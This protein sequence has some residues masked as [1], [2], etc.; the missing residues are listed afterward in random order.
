MRM[1]EPVVAATDRLPEITLRVIGLSIALTVILAMSNAYLALKIGILASASIPAAIISM[2]ILRRTKEVSIL[3]NNLVQ[4][5]ASAGEAIAGGIVYTA[6]ALILIH[7]WDHFSYMENVLIALLGGLLGIFFSTPLRRIFMN[8]QR[9]TFPEGRAIAEVLIAGRAK[10]ISFS[11]IFQGGLLGATVELL[12]TGLH[13]VSQQAQYWVSAANTLWGLGFGFS[14][15]MLGVGYLV[16]FQVGFSLFIGAFLGWFIGI[17]II[18]WLTPDLDVL[19]PSQTAYI[20]WSGK[21]RYVGVGAM[22][23]AGFITL[24]GLLSPFMASLKDAWLLFSSPIKSI[25]LPRTE[26]DIPLPYIMLGVMVCTGVLVILLHRQLPIAQLGLSP[27]STWPILF[28]CLLYVL[29][30]SF[31]FCT[32]TGYFSGLVGV[33][34]SPG[35]AIIIAGLLLAAVLLRL[36]LESTG[37]SD[38]STSKLA[39]AAITIVLGAIITGA[40]AIAN[41]NIQNLKV[42]H[43]LGGTPWKQQVMLILGIF[44]AA[45]TI[46]LV[47][48]LLFQVYGIGDVLPHP[49][50]DP[51]N[52][53]A[54]PPAAMMAAVTQGVFDYNLPWHFIFSG[55][56]II[57]FFCMFNRYCLKETKQFSLI[58]IAMG[59]YL[60][61]GTSMPL[62]LGSLV[63]FLAK[64][65]L[66]HRKMTDPVASHQYRRAFLMACGL[67]SGAAVMNIVL[68][69]PVIL[70]ESPD[71]IAIMPIN[72]RLLAD[73]LGLIAE[74]TICYLLYRAAVK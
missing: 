29:M 32:I 5:A 60:P 62:C 72:W 47:M 20:L 37:L 39:G 50:M 28:S 35:S 51:A 70:T 4:T 26:L 67:V 45:V 66:S 16:G 13:V 2:A 61:L 34:A 52:A 21:L 24:S 44:V 74:G 46:P 11:Q 8:D 19:Q 9:L 40:A 7:V 69:I 17:P 48:Q 38:Q 53:L 3:E 10:K 15:P 12:Q 54:A 57:V 22:L 30:I 41:D 68:A 36:L 71:V 42:G 31:I 58:G 27:E 25:Q 18:G 1:S 65:R 43:L 23:A 59:M 49:G 73:V 63:A 14:A 64:R 56:L 33:T 55:G 6:P